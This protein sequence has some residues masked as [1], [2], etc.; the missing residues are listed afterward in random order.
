[1]N[2][3]G[4][5]RT[6]QVNENDRKLFR[7]RLPVRQTRFMEKLI[8][9]YK[10][11]PDSDAPAP[12][13]YRAPEE[14]IGKDK[15]SPGVLLCDLSRSHMMLHLVQLLQDQVISPEDLEG[16]SAE[17]RERLTWIT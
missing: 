9:E 15:R 4:G 5:G 16:F 17:L 12:D 13:K 8:T 10:T 2:Q 14:R 6:E 7:S 1:M 11:L 3:K